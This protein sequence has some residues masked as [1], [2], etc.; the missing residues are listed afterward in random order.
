[1]VES[2]G[3]MPYDPRATSSAPLQRPSVTPQYMMGTMGTSYNMA[4]MSN[5][6]GSQYQSHNP[7]SYQQYTPPSPPQ[8][9]VPYR[10]YQENRPSLRVMPPE[11][12]RTSQDLGY[13]R[14]DRPIYGGDQ[15]NSPLIKSETQMSAQQPRAARRS[16]ASGT[17]TPDNEQNEGNRYEGTTEIDVLM[18]EIQSKVAAIN[19]V[20][21]P[22]SRY[23][24]PPQETKREEESRFSSPEASQ[25][26]GKGSRK[27]Y[28]C[29]YR[30]C[31]QKFSQKTH[32]EIHLRSHTGVKPYVSTTSRLA[33][34]ASRLT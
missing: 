27:R 11:S 5:M 16:L 2:S 33:V 8:M 34:L 29:D 23:Q 21:L 15:S 30:R 3:L 4:P 22:E 17:I 31:R 13:P 9:V 14:D 32:L 20:E 18:K 6:P 12:E 24:S 1:M 25:S 19:E 7:F 26:S 10:Q 28:P